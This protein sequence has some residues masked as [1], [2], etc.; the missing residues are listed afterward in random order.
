MRVPS[1]FRRAVLAAALAAVLAPAAA[2]AAPR[3]WVGFQDDPRFRWNEDRAQALDLA[4]EANATVVR[5]TVYWS[6]IAPTRPAAPADPFDPAYRFDDL[7]EMVRGA[8]QRGIEVLLTIWGTPRW[9]GPA[10]NRLPR[11]LADLAKFSRA[12]ASRYSGRH[13]GYPH[14]RFYSIWNEPNRQIFLAPQ[15][16]AKGR[17]VA[18][19]NY[20][21]LVRFAYAG[22]KTG[23]RNAVVAIGET[24]SNGRDRM[25][26][27]RGMQETH[28]P[29]R[30][31]QLLAA[32]RPKVKFD[33]WAHHPYPTRPSMRPNQKMRFP[34]VSLA[35]L[36]VFEKAIDGWFRRKGIPIWITE[37]G[38]E[39]KPA[40]GG[41]TPVQQRNFLNQA[42]AIARR[43]AR[44]EMFV[45]FIL[46]DHPRTPW[47]SGLVTAAGVRKPALARFSVLAR[48]MDARNAVVEVKGTN[49]LVR[50]SVL[51]FAYFSDAGAPIG[52]TYNLWQGPIPIS[53]GQPVV[54]LDADGWLSLR[55]EFTPR[56]GA[57]YTLTVAAGDE[58]GN[59]I[60]RT[61]FLTCP[62][63]STRK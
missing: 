62:K 41:I 12:L 1:L 28:S 19:A 4:Q 11:R 43:D 58:H 3:M 25:L 53:A 37:Y 17:S 26:G 5:T 51:P 22:I 55:P 40:R 30:F 63:P 59:S 45:W 15:Y 24:A 29:G 56:P 23:N 10:Q 14:V 50:V 34:N 61:L 38:H 16:N 18:P 6:R 8:Q 48:A 57:T 33:A 54:S 7:D 49:P 31:A 35:S 21:K 44:V 39:T 9:A 13:P 47:Q 32:A 42:F 46:K 2:T 52:I 27:R 60:E 20:A 36:P